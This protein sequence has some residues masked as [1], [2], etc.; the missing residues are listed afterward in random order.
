MSQP[1][2]PPQERGFGVHAV[3]CCVES[4]GRFPVA[5]AAYD[6]IISVVQKAQ[7]LPHC[8]WFL[9]SE[10]APWSLQ[11]TESG[12]S[13]RDLALKVVAA[14][15]AA[16]LWGILLYP[17][18]IWASNSAWVRSENSFT[19]IFHVP[20]A[21]CFSILTRLAWKMSLL[22]SNSALLLYCFPCCSRKEAN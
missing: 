10:T 14:G 4:S 5:I 9:T 19:P 6:S 12:S 21:L 18:V 13:L 7:Q 22:N 16:P 20:R 8:P 15:T 11:S 17:P 3:T 2:V 1:P